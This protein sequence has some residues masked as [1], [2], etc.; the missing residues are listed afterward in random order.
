MPYTFS[1]QV[2]SESQSYEFLLGIG[3]TFFSFLINIYNL[4]AFDKDSEYRF[5]KLPATTY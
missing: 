5:Y 2:P 4:G 1:A 3:Y